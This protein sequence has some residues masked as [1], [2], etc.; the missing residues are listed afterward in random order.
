MILATPLLS[1]LAF[2]PVVVPVPADVTERFSP[3]VIFDVV[4]P[5]SE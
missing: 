3:I 1:V 5:P 2:I 4:P